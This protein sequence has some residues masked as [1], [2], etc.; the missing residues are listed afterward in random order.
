[1]PHPFLELLMRRSFP[2]LSAALRACRSR[3]VEQWVEV[4]R[5]TLPTADELTF[6]QLRDDLPIIL[7]QMARA[8]ESERPAQTEQLHDM[9]PAHGTARYHQ[10]Y[11]LDELIV[12]YNLL[13]GIATQELAAQLA[14]QLSTDETIALNTA[15]DLAVRRGAVAFVE[16]QTHQLKAATEAQSKYL[17]FLSHDLRGELNGVFLMIEVL[18]REL[19]REERFAESLE[20]LDLMRRSIHQTIATMDR[21]LH[22]ERFRKGKVQ[23]RPADINLGA[24]LHEVGAQFSYQAK[25]KGL[26]LKVEAAEPCRAFTDKELIT[27]I[28][29]NLASNAVKYTPRGAVRLRATPGSGDGEGDGWTISVADQGPGIAP[30]KMSE[31]FGSFTRG[32]T[33][34][35]PGVGLG[36]SIAHQAAELLGAKLWAEST[37]GQGATFRLQLPKEPPTR[38]AEA[39]AMAN[40]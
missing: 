8:L 23:V 7:E 29:Q 24:V 16:H 19:S 21:F 20:D 28:L 30:E 33:H 37:P 3:I 14:R 11:N 22:A 17:S 32:D 38:A 10:S 1:M 5:Q 12:E 26:D 6:V 27:M 9:T 15:V 4:V 13:R 2:E 40:G 39:A 25:D 18:R 35:Q 34:G 31:L 36:L